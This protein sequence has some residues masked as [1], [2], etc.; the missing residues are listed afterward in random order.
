MHPIFA[1][2]SAYILL[3]LVSTFF[4]PNA[5]LAYSS[6][7][8]SMN[9][10][11]EQ[12]Q[13]Q[14]LQLQQQQQLWQAKPTANKSKEATLTFSFYCWFQ[15]LPVDSPCSCFIFSLRRRGTQFYPWPW[16]GRRLLLSPESVQDKWTAF[17]ES[18]VQ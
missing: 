17:V 2:A 4:T 16:G 11:K 15:Q 14:Q 3:L 10:Q 6:K 1:N 18:A 8:P 13:Q 7:L 5:F 9:Q 12:Q